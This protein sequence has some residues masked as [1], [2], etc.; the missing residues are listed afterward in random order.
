MSSS[1]PRQ[2]RRSVA[3]VIK[4]RDELRVL[5]KYQSQVIIQLSQ[6][7]DFYESLLT[8]AQYEL[9]PYRSKAGEPKNNEKG[10]RGTWLGTWLSTER[11]KS[12]L[13][14]T[15]EAWRKRNH[16]HA[17]ALSDA[18]ILDERHQ[19]CEI[20]V[21]A[22]LLKAVVE[23][24]CGLTEQAL[25]ETEEALKIATQNQFYN[26]AGIAQFQRGVSFFHL[27]RYAE[28]SLC[29]SLAAHTRGYRD[30]VSVWKH[31]GEQMRLSFPVGDPRR[32]IAQGFA[33]LTC[34]AR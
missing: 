23:R 25:A 3:N 12:A 18:I 10:A 2:L 19:N 32:Y 21:R 1:E 8:D 13:S 15:E 6:E 24:D 7:L 11:G 4:E 28:A 20:R 26:L 9:K 14:S 5:T 29:F 30:Q 34:G 17:I 31:L 33:A 22:R 27:E 16:Q